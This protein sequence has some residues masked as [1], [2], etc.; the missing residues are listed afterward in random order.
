MS[1]Y[2]YKEGGTP[3]GW[4]G[5][6]LTEWLNGEARDGWELTHVERA[7]GGWWALVRREIGGEKPT[8]LGPTCSCPITRDRTRFGHSRSCPV[9]KARQRRMKK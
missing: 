6:T 9:E 2:E 3:A 5:P 7:D 1:R 4:A 8:E